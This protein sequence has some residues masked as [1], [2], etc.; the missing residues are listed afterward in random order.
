MAGVDLQTAQVN[1]DF[2]MKL[3][4]LT[5]PASAGYLNFQDCESI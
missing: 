4:M 2:E 1:Q 5:A 3:Q